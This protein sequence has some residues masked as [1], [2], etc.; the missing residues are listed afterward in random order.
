MLDLQLELTNLSASHAR[1]SM[2]YIMFMC[3]R[4]LW[5]DQ[6][7]HLPRFPDVQHLSLSDEICLP[8]AAA[9]EQHPGVILAVPF[10]KLEPPSLALD[11]SISLLSARGRRWG[12]QRRGPCSATVDG[13]ASELIL[14]PIGRPSGSSIT[15]TE[16]HNQRGKFAEPY[17]LSWPAGARFFQLF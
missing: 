7:H 4:L 14:W 1:T 16:G 12:Q 5:E 11:P 17:S 15:I 13:L 8:N 3:P 6:K 2:L 9:P 10:S